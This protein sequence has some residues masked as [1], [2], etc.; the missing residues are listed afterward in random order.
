M[1]K[2]DGDATPELVDTRVVMRNALRLP[3]KVCTYEYAT[4]VRWVCACI[5]RRAARLVGAAVAAVIARSY[6]DPQDTVTIAMDGGL[7][8]NYKEFASSVDE[9]LLQLLPSTSVCMQPAHDGSGLGA[10]LLAAAVA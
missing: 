7:Y 1:A 10:A 3:L 9:V 4:K 8:H 6:Q 2:I 5:R